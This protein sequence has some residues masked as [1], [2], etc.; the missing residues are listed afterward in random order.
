MT[1]AKVLM[2]VY[3]CDPDRGSEPGIGW[4]TAQEMATRHDVW[5][6]TTRE[7]QARIEQEAI[8]FPSM[9]LVFVDLPRWLDWVK[10]PR[11]GWEAHHYAW[12]YLA[13]REGLRLHRAVHLDVVHHVTLGRLWM[14]S[15][16]SMLPVPFVWGPVGGGE[17]MPGKFWRG[18]G[19][20]GVFTE[21]SRS[22]ARWIAEWDPFLAMTARRSALALATTDESRAHIAKLG[23]RSIQVVS[24]IGISELEL[25]ELAAY[26]SP[27]SGPIRFASIGRLVFW[28]GFH[29]GLQA[30]ARLGKIDAEYWV[31]GSGPALA[32]L[33]ALVQELGIADRVRF[34][35]ALSRA[36]TLAQLPHLH[37]LVHPSLHEAGGM[38]CVEALAAGK[39]VVC[40]DLGGPALQVT[41]ESGFKVPAPTPEVAIAGLAAAMKQLHAS[42]ELRDR[43]GA[44][45]RARAHDFSWQRRGDYLSESYRSVTRHAPAAVR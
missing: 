42:R 19:A 33:T 41:E 20:K 27:E 7:N 31:I 14:P 15:F 29:L 36:D 34:H 38:V 12:Q 43:M 3:A 21:L 17:S 8:A 22:G 6:M 16:L 1:R 23:A 40:L 44:A 11:I 24:Q 39:P 18:L 2:S 9:R 10:L 28:K 4:N 32:S 13:Y 26:R 5:L 37:V 25:E 35:G 30:F 45:A